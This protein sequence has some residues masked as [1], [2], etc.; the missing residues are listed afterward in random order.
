MGI[1]PAPSISKLL[2]ITGK[3]LN[4]I[5][6]VEINEAFGAQTLAC[7]KELKLDI[8]K[9]NVNGGAIAIGHPL[10]ASGTRITSHLVHEIR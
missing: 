8:E 3:T 7:Q 6:L 9:L 2:S 4:D 1:G 5:D 10:A